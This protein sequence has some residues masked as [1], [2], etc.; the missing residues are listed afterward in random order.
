MTAESASIVE[1][2]IGAVA[3]LSALVYVL[4]RG[5]RVQ[6]RLDR[7]SRSPGVVAAANLPAE[8]E[9]ISAAI[10]HLQEVGGRW[11]SLVESL[12]ATRDA[13]T[14]LQ[15]GI[16]SVATCIIDLLDTF[17]PSQRGAAPE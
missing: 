8:G 15:T 3:V 16:D 1:I 9:R 17:A 11:D 12:T 2:L 6:S 13:G 14:R 10:Q 7:I 5:L 4:V